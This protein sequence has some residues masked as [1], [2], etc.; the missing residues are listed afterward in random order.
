MGSTVTLLMG[1]LLVGDFLHGG[2]VTGAFGLTSVAATVRL[3]PGLVLL[4]V[5]LRL[6]VTKEQAERYA[7]ERVGT[8]GED[9][10]E[11]FDAEVSPVGES[12]DEVPEA[13]AAD[14]TEQS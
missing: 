2:L 5:G 1:A 8:A 12:L 9:E 10:G 14:D 4:W 6:R 11:G 13:E 7:E 3:L